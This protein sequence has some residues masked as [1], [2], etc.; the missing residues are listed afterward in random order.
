MSNMGIQ[1]AEAK[2][3]TLEQMQHFGTKWEVL[4]KTPDG[5]YRLAFTARKTQK[6][7][8]TNAQNCSELVLAMMDK[9]NCPDD[10]DGL[11]G[12][13]WDLGNS[14]VITFGRTEREM[15]SE[16]ARGAAISR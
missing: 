4:L 5:N 14:V 11:N 2:P 1:F 10:L 9:Y 8:M 16:L 13:R 15:A 7:L 3:R 12:Q 6:A